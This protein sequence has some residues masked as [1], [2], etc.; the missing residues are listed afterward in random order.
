MNRS[1]ALPV[2]LVAEDEGEAEP[3]EPV[4]SPPSS[5]VEV[6]LDP[7]PVDV[8]FVPV[9]EVPGPVE[10]EGPVAPV[11]LLPPSPPSPGLPGPVE[12]EG[13]VAPVVLLPPSPPS[14]GLPGLVELEGP[15]APVVLLPPSPPS[16]GLPGLVELEGPVAPV[17]LLPPS[18]P[19]PGLPVDV[20]PGAE[21][22]IEGP[23]PGGDM[24]G[25]PVGPLGRL[26]LGP[27][28]PNPVPE[29]EDGPP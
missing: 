5:P 7:V 6:L 11:V 23:P 20:D 16:P 15:V 22:V 14:P 26:A 13:P 10:L 24:E 1:R 27:V 2:A 17:V 28:P 29:G 25:K 8:L 18:P 12:L 21:S 4:P 3:L 19:S 9:P